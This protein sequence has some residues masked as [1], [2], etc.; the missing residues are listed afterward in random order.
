MKRVLIL[1]ALLTFALMLV[2]DNAKGQ[3]GSE[4]DVRSTVAALRANVEN[5]RAEVALLREGFARV[6]I[7]RRRDNIRRIKAEIESVRADHAQLNDLDRARQQDL[8]DMEELLTRDGVSAEQRLD[9]EA[10]RS[11]LAVTHGREI[12][13]QSEAV[14]I[15]EN[16]LLRRLETEE[17]AA[18]RLE[19]ALK[20]SG[21]KR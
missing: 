19:E 7:E 4:A 11:E 12:A 16:E 15:R 2:F 9:A 21:G 17:Q 6:E 10:A 13:Q 5:L 3:D 18:N 1:S 14:R 8:R 20:N